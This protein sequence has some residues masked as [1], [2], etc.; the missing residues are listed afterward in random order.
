MTK[1]E[2]IKAMAEGKKLTHDSFTRDEWIAE[3]SVGYKFED[4]C[5]CSIFEFWQMRVSP[6]WDSDWSIFNN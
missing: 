4:G 6:A 3:S 2:A 1:E 5:Q